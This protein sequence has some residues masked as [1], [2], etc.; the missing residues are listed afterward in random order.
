V[1]YLGY[2]AARL[3]TA[4]LPRRAAY[5]VASWVAGVWWLLSP[6]VRR[7][8]DRNLALIPALRDSAR[9]RTTVARRTVRNFALAVTDFLRLP[10]LNT[11]NLHEVIAVEEFREMKHLLAGS[12]AILVT[13]HL[14]SWE[15]AAAGAA[16]I[17]IDLSVIVR[18][19][20]DRRVAAIFRRRREAKG[21]KVM[22]VRGA[23][24][25]MPAV[26]GNSSVALAGDRDFTGQGVPASFLGATTTVPQAYAALAASRG[27]PVIPVFCIRL[28]DGLYH[29]FHEPPLTPRPGNE[30]GMAIVE[31]VLK[32]SEKYVEKYPEQWYRFDSLAK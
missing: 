21:L 9:L 1:L 5:L 31:H 29:L 23:A 18:D 12:P 14:G 4:L 32:A 13:A 16:L 30:D 3:A 25:S 7:N 17:G 28:G 6:A 27:I 20:P 15:M 11:G 19:D 10:R 24:R 22:S 26:I 8:L 2:L